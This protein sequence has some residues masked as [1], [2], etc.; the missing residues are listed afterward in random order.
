[1]YRPRSIQDRQQPRAD[2]TTLSLLLLI[3]VTVFLAMTFGEAEGVI[4][5]LQ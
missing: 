2:K 4:R 1:M 5:L 3:I